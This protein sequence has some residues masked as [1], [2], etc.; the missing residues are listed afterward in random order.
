MT[1][2][3]DAGEAVE[4]AVRLLAGV[5]QHGSRQVVAASAASLLRSLHPGAIAGPWDEE[6]HQRLMEAKPAL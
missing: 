2:S 5:A 4:M 1:R 6:A 3:R